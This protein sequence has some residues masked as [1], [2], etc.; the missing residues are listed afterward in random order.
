MA[1]GTTIRLLP[2]GAVITPSTDAAAGA[3]F[4]LGGRGGALTATLTVAALTGTL[5]VRV[6]TSPTGALGSWTTAGTSGAIVATG[7]TSIPVTVPAGA[8][9]V[10]AFIPTV[11]TAT[12]GLDLAAPFVS[13]TADAADFSKEFRT[14][15]D[16]MA[17]L[18]ALGE[19]AILRE[20]LVV[21]ER[22]DL[23]VDAAT[24]APGFN[25]AIRAAIVQQAE[26]EFR[27]HKLQLS[28]DASAMVTLRD[29]PT[30]APGVMLN[31]RRFRTRAPVSVWLGR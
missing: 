31:L 1:T 6:E 26:H 17:R 25:A 7:V 8:H 2:M 30:L 15:T 21:D 12:L 28:S 13:A 11:T 27:R 19:A 18:V 22:G 3:S 9:H 16:G 29:F 23:V 14:F 4:A 5:T 20:L 24:E 10:R